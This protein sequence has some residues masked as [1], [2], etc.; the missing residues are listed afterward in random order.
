MLKL[1]K[2]LKII[3]DVIALFIGIAWCF[4]VIFS[5]S[6]VSM[7]MLNLVGGIGV[8]F[9]VYRINISAIRSP[10]KGPSGENK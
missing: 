8:L 5:N 10:K 4:I 3:V 9:I 7:K 1:T 2:I 6:P